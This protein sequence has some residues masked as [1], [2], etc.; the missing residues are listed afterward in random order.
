MAKG[1]GPLQGVPSEEPSV[2]PRELYET[3]D[4]RFVMTEV[5]K[6][7]ERIDGL[8]KAAERQSS[9][10]KELCK[11]IKADDKE[12]AKKISDLKES[13]DTFKGGMKMV[14]AGYALLLI[15]ISVGLAYFLRQPSAEQTKPVQPEI[16]QPS[17]NTA[18]SKPKG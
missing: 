2:Q 13:I 8:V 1:T 16:V 5:A 12:T 7:G 10:H 9:E 15:V 3:S 4:I 14:S 11:E 18:L 17:A 6:L